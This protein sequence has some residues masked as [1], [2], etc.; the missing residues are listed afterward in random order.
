[1]SRDVFV[2]LPPGFPYSFNSAYVL[3][4]FSSFAIDIYLWIF[5]KSSIADLAISRPFGIH[6]HLFSIVAYS[7]QL[8]YIVSKE[9]TCVKTRK[10]PVDS[11]KDCDIMGVSWKIETL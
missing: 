5:L 11:G 7:W 2:S 9:K 3:S 8:I 1:M 4:A 6:D 10:L